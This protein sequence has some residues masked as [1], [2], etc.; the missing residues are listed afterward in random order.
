MPHPAPNAFPPWGHEWTPFEGDIVPNWN[1]WD[2]KIQKSYVRGS[3]SQSQE[4]GLCLGI[5][6]GSPTFKP[7]L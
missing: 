2:I 3:V 7:E 1:N 6:L 4:T 5:D